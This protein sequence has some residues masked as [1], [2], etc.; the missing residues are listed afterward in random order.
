[1]NQLYIFT[2]QSEDFDE[3]DFDSVDD[4]DD[5]FDDD[6]NSNSACQ[7]TPHYQNQK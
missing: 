7:D 2:P 1:M 5:Y 6:D 4:F 3:D